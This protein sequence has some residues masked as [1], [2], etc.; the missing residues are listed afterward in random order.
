M[1]TR[2]VSGWEAKCTALLRLAA[3]ANVP[4]MSLGRVMNLS[5]SAVSKRIT[6]AKKGS[7]APPKVSLAK[8]PK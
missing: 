6:H 4:L 5:K 1:Q 2:Q 7:R 8:H 3:N